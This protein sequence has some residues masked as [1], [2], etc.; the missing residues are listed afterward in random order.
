MRRISLVGVSGSEKASV[1]R[2][3]AAAL[4][5]PFI[6]LDSIFHQPGW[7]DLPH[8]EFRRR[9]SKALTA[10]TWVVD[11][12]YSAVQYLAWQRADTVACWTRRATWPCAESS[13]AP[14]AARSPGERL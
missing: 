5:M 7:T 11:G 4:D 8:D 12:N 9:A 14:F 10:D 6:E 13:D 2:Q 1:G 3:L